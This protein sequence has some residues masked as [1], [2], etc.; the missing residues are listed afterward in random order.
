MSRIGENLANSDFDGLWQPELPLG[1]FS[2]GIPH[3]MVV[4]VLDMTRDF[5]V[6]IMSGSGRA[7]PF[8]AGTL[9]ISS[10]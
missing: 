7:E 8:T 6:T 3:D 1:L 5:A 4:A 9:T 10:G 2:L